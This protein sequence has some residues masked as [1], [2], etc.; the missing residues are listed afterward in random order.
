MTIG[1]G[2]QSNVLFEFCA[3]CWAKNVESYG[4]ESGAFEV[5]NSARVEINQT[6]GYECWNSVNSG[7]EYAYD[8]EGSSTENLLT[9]SISRLSGK[10]MTARGGGA[11]T[12]VSYNYMDDE[13]YDSTSGIGN[14]WIDLSANGTH[15]PGGHLMLF[16]GNQT[17]NMDGDDT[18]GSNSGY[19]TFFR[20]WATGY[21]TPFTDPELGT[22]LNDFTGANLVSCS[23]TCSAAGAPGNLRAAGPMAYNYWY[24]FVGNVMGTT[25]NNVIGGTPFTTAANGWAYYRNYNAGAKAIFVGSSSY[26]PSSDPDPNM[27]PPTSSSFMYI[28]G[29]YDFVN[30]AVTWKVGSHALPNSL[31]LTS[32]PAFFSA[33]GSCTYP[34]PWV[35]PSGSSVLLTAGGS[36]SCSSYSGLPAKARFDAG[37][38]FAQP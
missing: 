30:A 11:G 32:A 5:D 22:A 7:A 8:F 26:G 18:H 31:Y 10:N 37:K 13:F 3:Y 9:N 27:F 12:V 14:Y 28:D 36:G 15:L 35:T 24:A 21:R 16:E 34:W 6:Y 23:P 1:R 4:W 2:D 17:V 38:P 25:T 29:N 19:Y 20:N 33:G